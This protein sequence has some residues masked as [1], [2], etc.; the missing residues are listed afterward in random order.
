M[1][2]YKDEIWKPISFL[3]GNYE[4]SNYYRIRS[5][6]RIEVCSKN[7]HKRKRKG[8]FKKIKCDRYGYLYFMGSIN[9]IKRN[10]TIHRCYYDAF[11]GQIPD[12]YD[13]HHKSHIKTDNRA[14]NLILLP[15]CE[16][17]RMH[18]EEHKEE[19]I[20]ATIEKCSKPVCQYTLDG[21]FLNEYPSVIEAERQTKVSDSQI[22]KCCRMTHKYKSAG[23]YLWCFKGDEHK[24]KEIVQRN[25]NKGRK[26]AVLQYTLDNKFVAEYE[27][28]ICAEKMT[29]IKHINIIKCCK[30]E[31]KKAGGFIWKYK[32]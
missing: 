3:N 17:S 22:S 1:E 20:K 12:G 11:I 15:K 29:N 13:V 8:S 19:F 21:E 16:H 25:K 31:R 32:E 18:L 24:I 2:E 28:V 26:K 4:I 7:G 6:D 14:E 23:G 27:S 9:G 30:G 5:V 10:Y